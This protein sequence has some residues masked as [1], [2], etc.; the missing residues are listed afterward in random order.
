MRSAQHEVR[1]V[2]HEPTAV[3]PWRRTVLHWPDNNNYTTTTTTTTTT[4]NNNNNNNNNNS[5]IAL[6]PERNYELA[7]L[8]IINIKIRLTVPPQ[9]HKYYK[10]IHQY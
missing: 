4:T 5:Y 10:C 2:S 1:L 3:S 7:A 6:Y 8:Y 9:K